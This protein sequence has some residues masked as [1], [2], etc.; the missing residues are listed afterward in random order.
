[1]VTI[2][3]PFPPGGGTDI[4]ARSVTTKLA[5]NLK[6]QI[7]IDNRGGGGGNVA[8]ELTARAA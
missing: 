1:M 7:V 5:I 8:H 3:V 4:I 6:Q 2:V